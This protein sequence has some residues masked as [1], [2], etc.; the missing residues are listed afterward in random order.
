MKNLILKFIDELK[1][2]KN[3]SKLTVNVYL[4]NLNI[5]LEFLNEKNIKNYNRV[6]YQDIRDF[7]SYLY[8]LNYNNKTISRNISAIRSFFKFLKANNYIDNNPCTLISNPKLEKRLPKF[9]NFEDTNKL[10]NAFDNNNYI[11]LR[12]SIFYWSTS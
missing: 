4:Y 9:L 8:D 7:I 2:E 6:T 1:Y 3:Y 10:L 5:F 11:G 12:N